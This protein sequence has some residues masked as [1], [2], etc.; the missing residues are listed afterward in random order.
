M[1]QEVRV[2]LSQIEALL[3]EGKERK[4]IRTILGLSHAQV[5]AL[6]QHPALKNRKPKK[7]GRVILVDDEG[8]VIPTETPVVETTTT[9]SASEITTVEEPASE[10][11]AEVESV[12]TPGEE[13]PEVSSETTT[14]EVSEETPSVIDSESADD[15]AREL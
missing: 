7:V 5:Q 12:P 3:E 15:W 10:T 6:F 13:A 1:A 4:E 14:E 9:E 8:A 2:S 11:V